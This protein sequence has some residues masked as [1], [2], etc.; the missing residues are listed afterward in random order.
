M[1]GGWIIFLV[2]LIL[3][4]LTVLLI[5]FFHNYEVRWTR[6]ARTRRARKTANAP[7]RAR[8]S[9]LFRSLSARTEVRPRNRA[10]IIVKPDSMQKTVSLT[11][12]KDSFDQEDTGNAEAL[13][14]LFDEGGNT[15]E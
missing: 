12:D 3:V 9:K 8:L 6:G 2:A 13:E 1:R 14:E 15:D 11:E 7:V 5:W 4:A 10:R